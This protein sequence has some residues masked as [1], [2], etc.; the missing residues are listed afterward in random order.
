MF[1][2][3]DIIRILINAPHGAAT[4]GIKVTVQLKDVVGTRCYIFEGFVNGG[5]HV[6]ITGDLFLI[7]VP[8]LNFFLDDG[9]QSLIGCIDA[10]D[11]VRGIGT[12]DLCNFQQGYENIG[13]S[14]NE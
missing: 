5:Q 12:L 7:A 8:W 1:L 14:F 10:L 11:A 6:T 4:E 13:L 2:S 3:D 9:L